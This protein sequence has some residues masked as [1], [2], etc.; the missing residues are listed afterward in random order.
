M[1]RSL[2]LILCDLSASGPA[3]PRKALAWSN[4]LR[5]AFVAALLGL[6]WA[7]LSVHAAIPEPDLVWYGK[8][9]TTSGGARVRLTTG[10]LVWQIEPLGGGPSWTIST[11]LTNINDQFSFVLRIPCE[12]PEPG[13]AATPNIVAFSTPPA[14]Y[15]RR[16]VTLNGQPLALSG[17]ADQFAPTSRDRGR[18]EQIDLTLGA[19]LLDSDGD[20]LDD[21]WE[22]RYFGSLGANPNDDPDGDGVNNLGEFRAG[23]DPLDARSRFEIV[24]VNRVGP[25]F[26]IRWSSQPNHLYQVR[27]SATLQTPAADYQ[28]I[29]SGLNATPPLNEFVDTT[30]AGSAHFFYL[31]EIQP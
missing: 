16:T 7:T 3:T 18:T 31:I 22:L 8:V 5:P 26:R 4:A 10:T 6:A 14:G 2:P 1:Q 25:N 17:A 9:L 20:G 23:T 19:V 11:A 27:R 15:R 24:E 28:I 12:S 21:A 13:F 29:A 30:T